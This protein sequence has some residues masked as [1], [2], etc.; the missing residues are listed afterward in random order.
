MPTAYPIPRWLPTGFRDN[1]FGFYPESWSRTLARFASFSREAI[2]VRRATHPYPTIDAVP[3]QMTGDAFDR[4]QVLLELS[5]V[6]ADKHHDGR[7][8]LFQQWQ[9]V[10]QGAVRLASGQ[11]RWLL[12]KCGW[13]A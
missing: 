4:R 7:L 5:L 8:R 1:A 11:V 9:R 12:D 3:L 6:C 10:I 2:L 13:G